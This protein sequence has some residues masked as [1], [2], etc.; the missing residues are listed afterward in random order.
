MLI[1]PFGSLDMKQSF[2]LITAQYSN[3]LSTEA[4][5]SL[6]TRFGPNAIDIPIPSVVSLL[7]N[8]ASSLPP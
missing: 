7:L 5:A 1:P 3:G 2:S 6:M 4:H 8:E